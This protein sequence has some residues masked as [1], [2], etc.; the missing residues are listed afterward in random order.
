MDLES[1]RSIQSDCLTSFADFKSLYL[2]NLARLSNSCLKNVSQVSTMLPPF[3]L[4]S[5]RSRIKYKTMLN[6]KVIY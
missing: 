3:P 1:L 5:K 2:A 4:D 6:P